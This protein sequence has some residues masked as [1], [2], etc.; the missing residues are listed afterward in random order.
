MGIRIVGRAHEKVIR[1]FSVATQMRGNGGRETGMT[2]LN[3][4]FPFISQNTLWPRMFCRGRCF[5][6]T[7][8]GNPV[9]FLKTNNGCSYHAPIIS[10]SDNSRVETVSH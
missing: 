10:S 6:E 3:T 7:D 5:G 4:S 8:L 2:N 1:P 9:I